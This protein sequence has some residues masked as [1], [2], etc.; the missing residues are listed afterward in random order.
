MCEDFAPNFGDKRTGCCVTTTHRLTLPFSP[1]NF[2]PKQRVPHPPY[3]F[4]FSRLKIKLKSRHFDTIEVM[5][6]GSQT[7]LNTLTEHDFQDTF[8]KL[9]EAL[10][11]VRTPGRGILRG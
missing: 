10:A 2:L 9:A 4:L 11:T 8:K 7:V 5:E 3:F 1:G 6:A